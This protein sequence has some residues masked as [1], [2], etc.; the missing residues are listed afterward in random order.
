MSSVRCFDMR[1]KQETHQTIGEM[2]KDYSRQQILEGTTQLENNAYDPNKKEAIQISLSIIRDQLREEGFFLN[3]DNTMRFFEQR[4]ADCKKFSIGN[5][6]ELALM[7]LDWMVR[8]RPDVNAE[9]YQIVGGDHAF[10]VIGRNSTSNPS[11]PEEWG[12]D[13]YICDPWSNTVYQAR[14]YLTKTKNFYREY[15]AD[16]SFTNKIEDFNPVRHTLKPIP[17]QNNSHILSSSYTSNKTILNVF[18]SLNERYLSI[19]DGLANDLDKVADKLR[20]QYGENDPK[21]KIIKEQITVI[22]ETTSKLK[23]DFTGYINQIEQSTQSNTYQ[24]HKDISTE[25]QRKIKSQL[26]Q[27]RSATT[28]SD[29]SKDNLNTYRKEDSLITSFPENIVPRLS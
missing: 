8:K 14:E 4:V 20:I 21:F 6:H 26:Y 19:Y 13:T 29:A 27:L 12:D 28:L 25:L 15:N 11:R 18:T 1:T 2:A 3:V 9:I 24:S 17:N 7:A 23:A 16:G 10:L 22:R 5:C